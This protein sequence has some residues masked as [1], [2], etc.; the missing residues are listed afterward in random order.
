MVHKLLACYHWA[1]GEDKTNTFTVCTLHCL[2]Y[3]ECFRMH[4]ILSHY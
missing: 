2:H 4:E 1:F 3:Q